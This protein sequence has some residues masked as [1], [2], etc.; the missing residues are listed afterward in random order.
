VDQEQEAAVPSE[1]EELAHRY[2]GLCAHYAEEDFRHL[3]DGLLAT[4]ARNP[5]R[6]RFEYRQARLVY[7][8]Q[9]RAPRRRE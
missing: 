7:A 1:R 3:I 5:S 9:A 4:Q 6:S 2:R 8:T